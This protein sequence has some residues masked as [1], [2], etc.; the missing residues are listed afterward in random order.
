[1]DSVVS[2]RALV[3]DDEPLCAK[4]TGRILENRGY[5]VVLEYS[6]EAARARLDHEKFDLLVT[7]W[8]MPDCDGID[9]VRHARKRGERLFI[10][11]SSSLGSEGARQHALAAGADEVLPKPLDGDRLVELVRGLRGAPSP[12]AAVA[13]APAQRPGA[14]Q[15]STYDLGEWLGSGAMGRVRAGVAPDGTPVAIKLMHQEL[16]ADPAATRR[17]LR[18]AQTARLIRHPNVVAVHAADVDDATRAPFM[19]MDRLNGTSLGQL[20][21]KRGALPPEVATAVF[22]SVCN[23]LGALHAA[24]LVHRDV[25]PENIFL[26][27]TDEGLLIPKVCDMGLARELGGSNGRVTQAGA[28]VGSPSYMSPEQL[29]GAQDIDPRSDVFSVGVALYEALT[30]VVPWPDT[31]TFA[32]AVLSVCTREPTT[33]EATAPWIDAGLRV[34]VMRAIAKEPH[35]RFQSVEALARALEPFAASSLSP[36]D[37]ERTL[38]RTSGR[39]SGRALTGPETKNARRWLVPMTV[40]SVFVLSLTLFVAALAVVFGSLKPKM[41]ALPIVVR[42]EK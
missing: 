13:P 16:V 3:V 18:E 29:R 10:V 11:I 8:M 6:G 21:S 31:T 33:M 4:I 35:V 25:K 7:D 42:I 40:A 39:R 27:V 22:V 14:V 26:H 30:G 12:A 15:L 34:V 20:L 23:G 5:E 1:M 36:S 32:E 37:L 17:F 19:V 28:L 9:L 2:A 24:Q 38:D 41:G